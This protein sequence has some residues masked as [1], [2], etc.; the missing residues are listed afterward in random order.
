MSDVYIRVGYTKNNTD[1]DMLI[2]RSSSSAT[3]EEIIENFVQNNDIDYLNSSTIDE[4]LENIENVSVD[5]NFLPK[6]YKQKKVSNS[7][8]KYTSE[9]KN[10]ILTE[11]IETGKIT[12]SEMYIKNLLD[13]SIAEGQIVINSI[14]HNAVIEQD[15]YTITSILYLIAQVPYESICPIGPTLASAAIT[16]GDRNITKYAIMTFEYWKDP[17]A[18]KYLNEISIDSKWIKKYKEKVIARLQKG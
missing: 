4:Q 12:K 9:L 3:D 17:S 16:L 5:K 7:I 6:V 18:I 11:E 2:E 8:D 1:N 13:T 14:Y 10:L 15:N